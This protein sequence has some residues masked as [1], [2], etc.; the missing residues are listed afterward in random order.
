MA[1][2]QEPGPPT[3]QLNF[4]AAELPRLVRLMPCVDYLDLTC[5]GSE[6]AGW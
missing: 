5:V 6:T 1:S 2:A 4:S 3:E